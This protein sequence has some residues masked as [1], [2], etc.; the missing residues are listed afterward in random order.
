MNVRLVVPLALFSL[1]ACANPVSRKLEGRWIGDTITNLDAM[2][3][4]S[5]I[6]W[7]RG[8]SFEFAGGNVTVAVPTELPRSGEYE[9]VSGSDTEAMLSVRRPDGAIDALQLK[10]DGD[11]HLR[12]QVGGG[13]EIILRR[14][15]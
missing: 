1:S 2:Q 8:T 5:A 6:G 3:L 13:R 15:D 10:F 4:P 7:V 11:E 9:V 12:W 14:I